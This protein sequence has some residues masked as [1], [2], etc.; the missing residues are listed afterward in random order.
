MASVIR[1][2]FPSSS[3]LVFLDPLIFRESQKYNTH[4]TRDIS[5]NRV[6]SARAHLRCLAPGQ[7]SL[8]ETSQLWQAVGDA[9]PRLTCPE[10]EL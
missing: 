10:I 2:G 4:Y 7:H 3:P 8:E 6:N 9:V 5:P 1:C